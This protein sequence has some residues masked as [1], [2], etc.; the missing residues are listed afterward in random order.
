MGGEEWS[1]TT[2]EAWARWFEG[3][4]FRCGGQ[5]DTLEVRL[6]LR[7]RIFLLGGGLVGFCLVFLEEGFC[8]AY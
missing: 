2:R 3:V 5:G 7:F 6:G 8:L 1:L 4:D